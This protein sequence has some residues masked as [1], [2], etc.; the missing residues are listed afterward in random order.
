VLLSPSYS[1]AR[2]GLAT[3]SFVLLSLLA[4]LILPA[5]FPA[6]KDLLAHYG[7]PPKDPQMQTLS[8]QIDNLRG[9]TAV[10]A[11]TALA[12]GYWLA[13]LRLREVSGPQA[14]LETIGLNILF[15]I[16]G[17]YV[18]I[19]AA[20]LISPD[21]GKNA[22][23][24]F[25]W[26]AMLAAAPELLLRAL[27]L[28]IIC[29]LVGTL[30]ALL[31]TRWRPVRGVLFH[32]PVGV[33][34][35]GRVLGVGIAALAVQLLGGLL[36]LQTIFTGLGAGHPGDAVFLLV[37]WLLAPAFLIVFYATRGSA[38]FLRLAS[39]DRSAPTQP[40]LP[41]ASPTVRP[42]ARLTGLGGALSTLGYFLPWCFLSVVFLVSSCNQPAHLETKPV[43]PSGADLAIQSGATFIPGILV[44]LAA[45]ALVVIGIRALRRQ[46]SRREIGVALI[47]ALIGLA[48]VGFQS[49][50]LASGK[51][52]L[53]RA[54]HIT[55]LGMG[56]GYWLLLAGFVIG[57]VGGGMMLYAVT[58]TRPAPGK[59]GI[60]WADTDSARTL[61]DE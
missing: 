55:F 14:L 36:L 4:L 10:I 49:L 47:A 35:F 33:A 19:T 58:H 31:F 44:L 27:A 17:E 60:T 56:A 13:L 25:W 52:P 30:A 5:I 32:A 11:L 20:T 61:P 46:P 15:F 23:G 2:V 53:S 6:G 16:G 9:I 24:I 8:G 7:L 57:V 34:T 51:F 45:L 41:L 37:F 38:R 3:V 29:G 40:A 43:E 59:K 26:T 54:E 18:L 21:L 48:L 28:A 39:V 42:G 50:Q 12:C 1:R 22:S